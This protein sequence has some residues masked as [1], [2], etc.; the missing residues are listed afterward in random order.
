MTR[1]LDRR[2]EVACPIYDK[3]VQ[4]EIRDMIEMQLKDNVKARIINAVQDNDYVPSDGSRKIRSQ[5]EIYQYYQNQ[6]RKEE[7]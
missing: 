4:R 6:L 7:Y 2:V 5:V 1:N 3:D